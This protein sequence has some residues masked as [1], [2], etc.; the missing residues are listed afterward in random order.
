MINWNA[1]QTRA[2]DPYSSYKSSNVNKISYL[3]SFDGRGIASGLVVTISDPTTLQITQG[4]ALKDNV[5]LRWNPTFLLPISETTGSW[6]VGDNWV[7][8]VYKYIETKIEDYKIAKVDVIP[9]AS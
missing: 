8:M 4:V 5:T 1:L 9:V 7:V 2:V 3:L 6:V